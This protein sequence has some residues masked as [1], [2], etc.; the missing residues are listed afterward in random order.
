M[1]RTRARRPGFDRALR[2]AGRRAVVVLHCEQARATEQRGVCDVELLSEVSRVVE[3][4]GG[5]APLLDVWRGSVLSRWH[6]CNHRHEV[7]PDQ[8]RDTHG[9][10]PYDVG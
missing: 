2:K 3:C 7:C 5:D 10:R 8:H 9:I 1:Q 6:R 4:D